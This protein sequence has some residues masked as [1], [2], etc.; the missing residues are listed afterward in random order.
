MGTEYFHLFPISPIKDY[1]DFLSS[2]T[3]NSKNYSWYSRS[4]KFE[5][6]NM[7]D[8]ITGLSRYPFSSMQHWMKLRVVIQIRNFGKRAEN[9]SLNL[10][11]DPRLLVLFILFKVTSSYPLFCPLRKWDKSRLKRFPFSEP[12]F[13]Q[14]I[15]FVYL[16][17]NL[18]RVPQPRRNLTIN[19][20]MTMPVTTGGYHA[21][22]FNSKSENWPAIRV[23][24]TK[25]MFYN[26]RTQSTILVCEFFYSMSF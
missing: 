21:P 20:V 7:Q 8:P 9:K 23:K 4:P 25:L 18:K 16:S 1:L 22:N 10:H 13:E 2:I 11:K 19:W 17:L 5:T 15:I 14:I 26:F 6:F 12:N 24:N 3:N